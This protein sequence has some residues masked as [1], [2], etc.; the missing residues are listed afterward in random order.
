ALLG[1]HADAVALPQA[2]Q[3][4]FFGPRILEALLLRL[5]DLRHVPA[6]HPADMDTNLFLFRAVRTHDQPP[7][8]PLHARS[9]PSVDVPRRD[10]AVPVPAGPAVTLQKGYRVAIGTADSWPVILNA[11]ES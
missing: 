6:N 8:L 7:L 5:Q 4:V 1:H 11:A 9:T 3:K 2:A 10:A